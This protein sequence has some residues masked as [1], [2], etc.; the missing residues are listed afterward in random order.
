MMNP[1]SSLLDWTGAPVSRPPDRLMASASAVIFDDAGRVLL[2]RRA[3]NQRWGIPGGRAEIGESIA[4][5][6]IRE[7]F[8][9]TGLRV[10][11]KRLIGVYSDPT[12]YSIAAYPNGELV[13]FVNVCFEC[14]IEGGALTGSHEGRALRFFDPRQLPDDTLPAHR[15]RVEDALA[16]R[17][18]AFIR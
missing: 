12:R 8:E 10:S 11:V 4:Q 2:M 14:A 9:E 18:A 17:E 1:L 5:T 16:R 13:Q 3:D 15:L 6:V 7:V